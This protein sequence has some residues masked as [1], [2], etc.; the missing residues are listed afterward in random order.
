VAHE[1]QTG[2][3]V[4]ALDLKLPGYCFYLVH[5]PGH[6]RQ[7]NIDAFSTWLHSAR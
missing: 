2:D 4:R 7:K 3:L 6:P 5:A 1:L